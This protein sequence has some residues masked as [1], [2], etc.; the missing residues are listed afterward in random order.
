MSDSNLSKLADVQPLDLNITTMFNDTTGIPETIFATVKDSVGDVWFYASILGIFL[1][2]N[3]LFYRKED[4]FGYD[5]SR[6]L[7]VSSGFSFIISVSVLLSNWVNTIYPVI[8]F[9]SLTF[10]SFLMVYNLKKKNM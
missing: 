7:L 6:S 2:F 3:F 10:I 5:I 4:N 1:I 8:W 9:G